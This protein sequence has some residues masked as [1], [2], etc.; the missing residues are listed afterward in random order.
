M[1]W[2]NFVPKFLIL[3]IMISACQSAGGI[4]VQDYWL[5]SAA[6]GEISAMYMLMQNRS[7]ESDELV[8][9]SSNIAA[10]VEIHETTIDSNG[11]MQMSPVFSVPLEPE[12]EIVFEPGGLHVMFIRLKQ[13]L[14]VGDKI[15]VALHFKNHADIVLAVPVQEGAI[16]MSH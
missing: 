4:E 14:K 3:T 11:A 7:G 1:K 12:A 8:S 9:V 2:L 16:E 13:D 5:R 6:Q 10:A 15:E